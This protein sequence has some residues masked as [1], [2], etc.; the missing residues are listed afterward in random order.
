MI[1]VGRGATVTAELMHCTP[2]TSRH[3]Y[4]WASHTRIVRSREPVRILCLFRINQGKLSGG[5]SLLIKLHTI[6][7]VGMSFKIYCSSVAVAPSLIQ[8]FPSPPHCFPILV[9]YYLTQARTTGLQLRRLR[10]GALMCISKFF[11]KH[12]LPNMM[13]ACRFIPSTRN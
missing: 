7:A 6:H 5:K 10:R 2:S 9:R 12:K 1:F 4:V 3:S 13:R 8:R 11:A